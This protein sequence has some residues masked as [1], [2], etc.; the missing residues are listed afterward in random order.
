MEA[1]V[2]IAVLGIVV[3]GQLTA[4]ILRPSRLNIQHAQAIFRGMQDAFQAG[5]RQASAESQT[6]EL[7]HQW[8]GPTYPDELRDDVPYDREKELED[9]G[10]PALMPDGTESVVDVTQA[11]LQR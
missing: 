6:K 4:M 11:P 3:L 5:R 2:A 7:N 8:A 9:Q 10:M 1:I